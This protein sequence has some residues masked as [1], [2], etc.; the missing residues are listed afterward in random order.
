MDASAE[1]GVSTWLCHQVGQSLFEDVVARCTEA[2]LPILAVKGFATARTL[3]EDTTERPISDVDVR[4]RQSDFST[5]RRM[6]RVAGWPCVYVSTTYRNVV[7]SF[8]PLSLDVECAIGAPGVCTMTVEALL[9]RAIPLDA[10]RGR[11]IL[12]P[13]LH[14]HAILLVVNAFKDKLVTAR[15]GAI[16]DLERIVLHPHFRRDEFVERT[17][18]AGVFTLTWIVASW[19]ESERRSLAWGDIR[20]SLEGHGRPRRAYAA[21]LERMRP[22]APRAPLSLRLLTRVS[23]DD[24]AMRVKALL[25]AAAWQLEMWVRHRTGTRTAG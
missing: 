20:T 8:P 25:G 7:Y 4:I 10:G 19:M 21:M 12:A 14:D 6:A 2:R 24:G 16:S 23:S 13:E 1:R 22:D 5:F 15:P 9:S 17:I 18:G 11:T 3:Y